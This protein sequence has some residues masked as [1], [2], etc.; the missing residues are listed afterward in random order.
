[1][2]L[3]ICHLYKLLLAQLSTIT[4][5]YLPAIFERNISFYSEILH[6][7]NQQLLPPFQPT[8]SDRKC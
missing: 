5:N 7:F 2:L 3:L 8:A 1:M 4:V 6:S